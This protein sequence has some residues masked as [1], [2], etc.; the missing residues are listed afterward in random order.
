VV[1]HRVSPKF[2]F[3]DTVME[4]PSRWANLPPENSR[5]KVVHKSDCN[6]ST[7]ESQGCGHVKV[8]QM[9]YASVCDIRCISIVC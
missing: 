5:G 4:R 9:L 1:I 8:N 3:S 2:N 6:L 7:T